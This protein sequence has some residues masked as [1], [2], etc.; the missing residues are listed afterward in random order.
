MNGIFTVPKKLSNK[1]V[2]FLYFSAG[3]PLLFIIKVY[4]KYIC[5]YQWSYRIYVAERRTLAIAYDKR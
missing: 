1:S 5:E 2:F 4:K 3:T